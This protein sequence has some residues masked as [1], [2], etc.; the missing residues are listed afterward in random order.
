[1]RSIPQ[2]DKIKSLRHS[3]HQEPELSN[4]EKRTAE[5]LINFFNEFSPDEMITGIGGNG[6]AAVFKSNEVGPTVLFRAELDALPIEEINDLEYKSVFYGISHKCGH[7]GHMSVLA[8]L[9]VMISIRK[10]RRGKVV[11]LFQPAEETGQGAQL[12]L[13][14]PRFHKIKPDYVFALHNLPGFRLNNVII[15]K[16]IFASASRG[17]IIKLTGKTSHAAEPEFGINPAPAL[18]EIIKQFER[19]NKSD[20]FRE[21]T[22]ITVI[23]IKLGERAFGTSPGSA[24]IFITL[25]SFLN[26]DMNL[27]IEKCKKIIAE[28]AS[29]NSLKYEIEH[30]EIFPATENNGQCVEI[31][32][33]AAKQN[34]LKIILKE[35]PFKWSEDFGH[36]TSEFKGAM[37]GLG[38]GVETPQLHNP[39][40]DF[41]D[42]LIPA[43]ANLFYS[44]INIL[45]GADRK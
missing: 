25:R 24:E 28:T 18:A 17:M 33:A 37:F 19:V 45:T 5:K 40:Y 27:L 6:F 35:E 34:D 44:I 9:A 10:L 41:P 15:R 7:D 38:A 32:S 8:A 21:F 22:L 1:M 36:F 13:K 11:L 31:I 3:L 39:D 2:I 12:I 43:G 14:D 4:Q 23:H 42:L 29:E 26:D 30:T 20:L 16:G